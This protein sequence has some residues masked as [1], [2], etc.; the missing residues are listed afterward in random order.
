MHFRLAF[1]GFGTVGQGLTEILL[2]K[3]KMLAENY[4]FEFTIVAISDMLKGSVYDEQGLDMTK[5]L[6]LVKSGK[7]LDMYP[8]GR[9]GLNSIETIKETNADVIIEV[10][11]IPPCVSES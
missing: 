5:I 3:K 10:T 2:E 8:S 6:N 1:L 7:K 4:D 9:K 11:Y